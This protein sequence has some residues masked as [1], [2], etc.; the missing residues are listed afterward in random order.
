MNTDI[1]KIDPKEFGIEETK[2]AD[3]AAQF[4]PMLDK[5]VELETDYNSIIAMPIEEKETS[6]KARELRLKYAKIRTGTT[7]I[8][9]VQKAFYLAGGRFVDG[10]KNAQ[11]FASLGKEE[12]LEKIEK[13]QEN[14]EKQRVADLQKEREL[15]LSQYEVENLETLNLGKMADDVFGNFLLGALTTYEARIEAERVTREAEETRILEEATER[16]RV[17]L[18]NEQLK[19]ELESKEKDAQ[20]ERERLAFIRNTRSKELTQYVTFITDYS[21]MLDMDEEAYQ[22]ELEVVKRVAKLQWEQDEKKRQADEKENNRLIDKQKKLNIEAARVKKELEDKLKA[23]Q[24]A[25]AKKQ[26]DIEAEL[27]MGDKAKMTSLI[28]DLTELKTKY[29]FKS[30]KHK[31]LH[32]AISELIDKT[33]TYAES[34]I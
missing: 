1:V 25:E 6:K 11:Q 14:I 29:S 7:D 3:I 13:H 8:H 27:S 33:V 17:R 21:S 22:K 23:E 5:M 4:K 24:D 28:N 31:T 20:A 2:A 34:K 15:Q 30:K 32:Q 19:A 10:W 9:K 12:E 18:E 26:A 16:E